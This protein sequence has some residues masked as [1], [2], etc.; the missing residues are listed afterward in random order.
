VDSA[1]LLATNAAPIPDGAQAY[2]LPGTDNLKLRAA[3][4]PAMG[5]ARGSVVVSPGRAEPI[6]K[7]FELAGEL[8]ARGFVVLVHDWRG[9]GLSQRVLPDRLKGHAVGFADFLT[10]YGLMLDAMAPRLPRPWIALAHS[11][12]GALV[13]QAVS[14]GE[15]RLAGCILCAP[16]IGVA[17]VRLMPRAARWIAAAACR[18]GL[19]NA[20]VLREAYD[21]LTAP[22]ETNVLTHDR[23]RYERFR[24]QLRACPDLLLGGVTWGWLDYALSAA[25]ALARPAAPAAVGV[26]LTIL[27]AGDD[28]LVVNAAAQRFAEAAPQGR[29]VEIPKAFHELMMETDAVR[30]V[31]WREFDA[32]ARRGGVVEQSRAAQAEFS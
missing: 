12:G 15:T 1:P 31:F 32:L 16:M 3:V 14:E 21:P 22:F 7:Y 25:T 19:T 27:G 18:L 5:A 20:Y 30:L 29:Y 6:E 13:L 8:G 26:P 11:M 10:D 23:A 17:S 2:W 9:Q 28:R 24:D 4:F